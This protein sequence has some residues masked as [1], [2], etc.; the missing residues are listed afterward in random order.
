[1]R[2]GKAFALEI[3][4]HFSSD[5]RTISIEPMAIASQ[6]FFSSPG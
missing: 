6:V 1:M 3:G 5:F 4:R 2:G